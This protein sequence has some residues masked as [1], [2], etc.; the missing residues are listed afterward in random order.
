MVVNIIQRYNMLAVSFTYFKHNFNS[1]TNNL[2]KPKKYKEKKRKQKQKHCQQHEAPKKAAMLENWSIQISGYACAQHPHSGKITLNLLQM[3]NKQVNYVICNIATETISCRF[4]WKYS[5][6]NCAYRLTFWNLFLLGCVCVCVL[7]FID[8]RYF[9]VFQWIVKCTS[10]L[11]G[12]NRLNRMW[13]FYLRIASVFVSFQFDSIWR[14]VW[15][16]FAQ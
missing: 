9:V 6:F 14:C 16:H 15:H 5:L 7:M 1:Y 11:I 10:R 3:H 2:A 13:L 12:W 4:G 8:K